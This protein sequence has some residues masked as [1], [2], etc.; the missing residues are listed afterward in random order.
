MTPVC[1]HIARAF[2]NSGNGK[3][4]RK[5][6]MVKMKIAYFLMHASLK[7]PPVKQDY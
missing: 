3:L 2:G 1:G 7:R 6:E 4:K 5:T